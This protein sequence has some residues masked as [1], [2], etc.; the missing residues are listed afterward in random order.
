LEEVSVGEQTLIAII[1]EEE[2][3]VA[4]FCIKC[5]HLHVG[6]RKAFNISSMSPQ[7]KVF[8]NSHGK[9]CF[10]SIIPIIHSHSCFCLLL[11]SH[12]GNPQ[13]S[14][15]M[16]LIKTIKSKLGQLGRLYFLLI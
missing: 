5:Q 4:K 13:L 9:H 2:A 14:R 6:Q 16:V 3:A 8:A 7:E 10:F 11:L 15:V 1:P 12:S